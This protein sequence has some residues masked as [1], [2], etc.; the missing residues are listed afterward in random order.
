MAEFLLRGQQPSGG[1]AGDP[2]PS[3]P[4]NPIPITRGTTAPMAIG[5]AG[6]RRGGAATIFGGACPVAALEAAGTDHRIAAGAADAALRRD[7]GA[8]TASEF[9]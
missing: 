2:R 4:T 9:F 8:R 7:A 1:A 3:P 5:G 6:S